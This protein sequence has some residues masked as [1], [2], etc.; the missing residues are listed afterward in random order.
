MLLFEP[1]PTLAASS[2]TVAPVNGGEADED[3]CLVFDD[4]LDGT[5]RREL[6]GCG[7]SGTVGGD[8]AADSSFV[9]IEGPASAVDGS[10]ASTFGVGVEA[11]S[12]E[13]WSA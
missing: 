6:L 9:E 11:R 12:A 4:L 10:A 2:V 13:S 5:F 7:F 1:R 3:S 8:C